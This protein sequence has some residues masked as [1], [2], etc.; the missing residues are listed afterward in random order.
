MDNF[1]TCTSSGYQ[2]LP[3]YQRKSFAQGWVVR[4][5]D[6]IERVSMMFVGIV[7]HWTTLLVEYTLIKFWFVVRLVTI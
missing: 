4:Q 1:T 6:Q 2:A 7:E 5:G 3:A